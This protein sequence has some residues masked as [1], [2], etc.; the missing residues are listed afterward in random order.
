MPHTVHSFADIRDLYLHD[1]AESNEEDTAKNYNFKQEV[2]DSKGRLLYTHHQLNMDGSIPTEV[3]ARARA[4]LIQSIADKHMGE[5]KDLYDSYITAFAQEADRNGPRFGL[6]FKDLVKLRGFAT[7]RKFATLVSPWHVLPTI[8]R[9]LVQ[10][11]EPGESITS[12][13]NDGFSHVTVTRSVDQDDKGLRHS[14]V[15]AVYQKDGLDDPAVFI[16]GDVADLQR[17]VEVLRQMEIDRAEPK[18][19]LQRLKD[20]F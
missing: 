2:R 13:L 14:I 18:S 4:I 15:L 16:Y 5:D 19:F 12:Y 3:N 9:Y 17:R 1:M 20:L 10:S 11:I 6:D 8:D 7:E